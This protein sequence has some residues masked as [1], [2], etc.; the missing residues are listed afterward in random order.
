ME[1]I[2][3]TYKQKLQLYRKTVLHYQLATNTP[4]DEIPTNLTEDDMIE[5]IDIYNNNKNENYFDCCRRIEFDIYT[6]FNNIDELFK[7]KQLRL[8]KYIDCNEYLFNKKLY[9]NKTILL[10]HLIEHIDEFSRLIIYL[11]KKENTMT[12]II[13][14]NKKNRIDYLK[15]NIKYALYLQ[16]TYNIELNKILKIAD[17]DSYILRF[18]SYQ[19]IKRIKKFS[20]LKLI[21]Y[22]SPIV[23]YLYHKETEPRVFYN[24]NELEK[25]TI[26]NNIS[27]EDYDYIT[28]FK[29]KC[30]NFKQQNFEIKRTIMLST[31]E[32]KY[33]NKRSYQIDIST[34]PTIDSF[35][36]YTFTHGLFAH[37]FDLSID[38]KVQQLLT[39]NNE[40]YIACSWQK[41]YVG[42]IGVYI[43]GDCKFASNFDLGSASEKETGKRFIDKDKFKYLIKHPKEIII[44]KQ[45]SGEAILT[46]FKI[47]GIWVK[48]N[49]K[50]ELKEKIK[51]IQL[52]TGI[53]NVDII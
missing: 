32:E 4:L 12:V 38:E 31:S 36:N 20:T 8:F 43:Q 25:F 11:N 52:M 34:L 39:R 42:D 21:N 5:L 24:F 2:H 53:K 33:R 29:D 41:R 10:N 27:E 35:K 40:I 44:S 45:N 46:N 6:K 14:R 50:E 15:N 23:F 19:H 7:N 1:T 26:M 9:K 18:E 16:L 3:T 13:S 47:V 51:L 28:Y 22:N 30:Y 37:V 48:E 49:V 17:L